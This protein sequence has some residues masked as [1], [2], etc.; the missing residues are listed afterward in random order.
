MSKLIEGL[1]IPTTR[2]L[3]ETATKATRYA[4]I[5]HY[6]VM[7]RYEHG[8]FSMCCKN[9]NQQQVKNPLSVV[10]ASNLSLLV[11]GIH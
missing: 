9:G 5:I 10:Y 3:K 7:Y 2:V 1:V 8:F 6:D 4:S 11:Y